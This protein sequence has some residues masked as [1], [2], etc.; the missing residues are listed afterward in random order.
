ME[1]DD[2]NVQHEAE[3]TTEEYIPSHALDSLHLQVI[4]HFT[5]VLKDLALR[6]RTTSG[7]VGPPA[8]SSHAPGYRRK[9]FA[10]WTVGDSLDYLGSKKP[11]RPSSPSLRVFLLRPYTDRGSRRGQDWSRRDWE[12][13]IAALQDMGLKFEDSSILGSLEYL[14]VETERVFRTPLRPTGL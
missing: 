3:N 1:V 6:V 13:S 4:D 14:K 2:G 9:E 8:Q 7:D 10:E 12:K 11:L 5:L